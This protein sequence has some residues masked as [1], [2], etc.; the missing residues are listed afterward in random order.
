M[1][2]DYVSTVPSIS[3][4]VFGP[5]VQAYLVNTRVLRAKPHDWRDFNPRYVIGRRK[6]VGR[7]YKPLSKVH[8]GYPMRSRAEWVPAR[9]ITPE[10]KTVGGKRI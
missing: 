2:D 5:Y 10:K 4:I 9:N 8:S 6:L 1:T 7:I 3:L